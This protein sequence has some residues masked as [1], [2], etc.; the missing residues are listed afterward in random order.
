MVTAGDFLWSDLTA[1]LWGTKHTTALVSSWGLIR[2]ASDSLTEGM[3][4]CG[5]GGELLPGKSCSCF[6]KRSLQR[7]GSTIYEEAGSC[8]KTQMRF[9]RPDCR[10]LQRL[11]VIGFTGKICTPNTRLSDSQYITLSEQSCNKGLRS[12]WPA[13][14]AMLLCIWA[15]LIQNS[16][17]AHPL[18]G[19]L[20]QG[21]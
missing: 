5:S 16:S 4:W 8:I 7:N 2:H 18:S 10:Q 19:A 11:Y 14:P 20:C 12:P 13:W 3:W 15:L 17:F 9:F 6:A 1:R 21:F